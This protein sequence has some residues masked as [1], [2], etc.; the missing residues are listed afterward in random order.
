MVR[1]RNPVQH[2]I[3]KAAHH[4]FHQHGVCHSQ[5]FLDF[6][7]LWSS[8]FKRLIFILIPFIEAVHRKLEEWAISYGSFGTLSMGGSPAGL[9]HLYFVD[10]HFNKGS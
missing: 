2:P 1:Q 5:D 7:S 3:K 6:W 10:I 4:Q 8:Y 9:Y